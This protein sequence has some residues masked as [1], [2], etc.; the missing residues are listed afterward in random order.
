MNKFLVI[1]GFLIGYHC[2][3]AQS[4]MSTLNA[5]RISSEIKIDGALNDPAWN[6]APTISDFIQFEPK[7]G[8]A[9]SH[10]TEIKVLYDDKA[11]YI[12]AT[13]LDAAPDSINVQLSERDQIGVVDWIGFTVDSYQDGQNGSG[14]FVTASGNQVDRKFTANNVGNNV[15]F[16]G[17]RSWDAVWESKV[18]IN[19]QGWVAEF[20]IPYSALRF[21]TAEIQ[22]W[23]VNF[24]RMI[25]RHREVS[26]WNPIDPA[27]DGF[28]IQSGRLLGLQSIKSPVRL[29]ATPFVAG[30]L[31]V[32]N[33]PNADPSISNLKSFN[34]GMDIRYGINDAFTVDMT[35]IPDF[36]EADSDEQVLNLSP[37]EVRFDENRQFFTEG[38]ELFNRGGLFYSRRVGDRPFDRGA[39]NRALQTNEVVKSNPGRAQLINATKLSGRT[40]KGLG[41]GLFNAVE[42]SMHAVLENTE[43]GAERLVETNPLTNYNVIVFNQ[44]L[45]NNSSVTLINTNVY[46]DGAAYEANVTGA[47]INLSDKNNKYELDVEGALSQKYLETSVD[48]GHKLEVEVSKTYGNF[49]YSLG[50]GEESDTYDP[51][52]LGFLFNNNSREFYA[53]G[54][55]SRYEAFGP[56]NNANISF[57]IGYER[58]YAP[59][60]FSSLGISTRSNFQSKTFHN[61]GFFGNVQPI[62]ENNYF[63]TRSEDLSTYLRY[64][65]FG[66]GGLWISSDYRK[67]LALD[68]EIYFGGNRKWGGRYS[69]ISFRPRIQINN[70]LIVRPGLNYD[71]SQND[72]QYVTTEN[73]ESIFGN[74]QQDVLISELNFT[75][76][77]TPAISFE[78]EGRHYWAK[79]AYDKFW[80]VDQQGGLIPTFYEKFSDINFNAF[81]IDSV[82]RWRFAPGSDIFFIWKNSI[83]SSGNI[84]IP[85]YRENWKL[86][87]Q[88]P[89]RNSFSL[90]VIYY[91]DYLSL[92][93]G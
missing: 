19:D 34:G 92:T 3:M 21:P 83:F 4:A 89:T 58:L 33:N 76:V 40:K 54:S 20:K 52:D 13:M 43:T 42:S 17:D 56:F 15:S 51:N 65:A 10:Q 12:A 63:V 59:N 29:S 50:Y 35:L 7:P 87:R 1:L 60:V 57:G 22:D 39:A 84:P 88:N 26:S 81:T 78:L 46:R 45:K 93:K 71:W 5:T 38:T 74:S 79:V 70:H 49:N 64:P 16:S 30:Y 8:R 48:L 77:F 90:K 25:R 2:S 23:N 85:S 72:P 9:P 53:N 27:G 31:E 41:I 6:I 86:L 68:A 69:G 80:Q 37:F 73:D 91:L 66:S 75:Y 44:N 14:F 82:F 47:N 32:T 61:F 55:L 11:I 67:K 28:L 62:P 18:K 24:F 36:G